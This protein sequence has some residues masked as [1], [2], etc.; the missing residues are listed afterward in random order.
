M[1]QYNRKFSLFS[2]SKFGP[3]L[4]LLLVTG[5]PSFQIYAQDT[6]QT[7]AEGRRHGKWRKFYE[8]TQQLRYEGTFD[9]GKE[10]GT[11][12]F[13]KPKSGNQPTA[14]K[15]F[16]KDSDTVTVTYFTSKGKIISRGNMVAKDRVGDWTYYH[17]D[18]K[19]MM[20]TE[21]YAK[22]MLDGTQH[23]YFPN[24]KLAEKTNYRSGLKH[25]KSELY[26]EQGKLLKE[27]TYENGVL[28]GLTKYYD[29]LGNLLIE[30]NYKKDRKDGIWKY[31]EGGKLKEEKVFPLQ[32]SRK[33]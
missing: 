28:N 10:V 25:G 19:Q 20:M 11:F 15:V 33:P 3:Y 21:S 24:G 18:G 26:S 14:T 16:R 6:N 4:L 23:T 12:N 30:G 1:L 27:F 22:G 13:Y 5:V 2:I 17:Q 31:Y 9:H 32:K 8:N 29:G 7:D